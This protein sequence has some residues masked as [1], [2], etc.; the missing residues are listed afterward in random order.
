MLPIRFSILFFL[1]FHVA[2]A[3]SKETETIEVKSES[4][5]IKQNP[6]FAKN[7]SGVQK[8]ILLDAAKNRYL[9]LPDILER[10][11]GLRVR[12]YGGLGSYSTLSIRGANPNQTRVYWNGIPLNQSEGGE[13]NLFDLPFDNLQKIEIYKSGT[14]AGFSG[15][16]I[17]GSINLV[18]QTETKKPQTRINL[19][20]GSFRSIKGT[21]SHSNRF[22]NGSYFFHALGEKSDQNF[23]YL[24]NKGTLLFN[25]FDDTID[26]RRNAQ[27][28]KAGFT[29]NINYQL[30]KTNL[31][32]LNDFIYRNQGLPGPG[33][34]QTESVER[35]FT[36]NSTALAT[37]TS[38]FIWENVSLETKLYLNQSRDH[39]FDPRSEFSSGLPNSLTDIKQYGFQ[40]SPIIYLP[41]YSQILRFSANAEQE[42]F[43]RQ[44]KRNNDETESKDPKRRRDFQTFHIQDEI[45][46]L[47]ERLFL[48]PQVRFDRYVDQFGRDTASLRNQLNDP[49]TDQFFKRTNF[50]NPS[51]GLKWILW[52]EDNREFG[53]MANTSKDYRI[54]SFIELFGE[55]GTIVGN[56]NL[57]PEISRN[58]DVGFFFRSLLSNQWKVDT[59]ISHFRKKIYDMIL[60]IPNSQFTLRPENID[61]ASVQG[62]ET[63]N[64]ITW[65]KGLKFNFQY[66]YQNAIN[67]SQSTLLN[68]KYLPLRPKNQVSALIGYFNDKVDTGFEYLFIGANYRDRTNEYFGYLPARQIYNF[69]FTYIPFKDTEQGKELLFTFEIR[70]LTDK[71][72][73]DLVGYPLPGR[74]YYFTGSYRF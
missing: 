41:K 50:T 23:S 55:R 26:R 59:E 1:I 19:Q 48:V 69:Y 63:S 62:F 7:P 12:Q 42:F 70:N 15:S 5:T 25:T 47:K 35:K 10:E 60:F 37:K 33:N 46:L 16:S 54:P 68:G 4:N 34:R 22:E 66:T 6:N 8:E 24:N 51:I 45:R 20:G 56:T 38:E 31:Q 73:E 53:L 57:R 11:A 14:P 43:D 30:G 21:I 27:Y 64:Q 3:Q 18:S 40:V 28:E 13:I 58:S 61:S 65:N 72:V 67:L 36:K 2:F 52:K 39:L 71:K 29:G 32:F 74:S 17:G 49:L 9:S 44:R